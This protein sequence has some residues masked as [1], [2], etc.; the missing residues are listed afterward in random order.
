MQIKGREINGLNID[1]LTVA[2]F[3]L[4]GANI[5]IEFLFR[6]YL[7]E[8]FLAPA[9]NILQIIIFFILPLAI[10]LKSFLR[11]IIVVLLFIFALLVFHN[12]YF[13]ILPFWLIF[14]A[15][16]YYHRKTC[17]QIG[18]G[19]KKFLLNFFLGVIVALIVISHMFATFYLG[20]ASL[21]VINWNLLLIK[22]LIAGR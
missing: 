15:I 19:G 11:V 16:F 1:Q 7:S 2:V 9:F 8:S 3:L 13:I 21:P 17:A 22:I 20:E 14:G 18:F 4:A 10:I 5:I 12:S 6:R